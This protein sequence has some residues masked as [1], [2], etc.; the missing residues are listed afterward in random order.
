[1]VTHISSMDVGGYRHK[2]KVFYENFTVVKSI[3]RERTIIPMV[4]LQA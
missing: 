2:Y 3:N 1:M 4:P